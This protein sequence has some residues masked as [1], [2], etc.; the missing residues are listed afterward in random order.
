MT[1]LHHQHLHL[2]GFSPIESLPWIQTLVWRQG[3]KAILFPR[4]FPGHRRATPRFASMLG[5][6]SEIFPAHTKCPTRSST[7]APAPRTWWAPARQQYHDS[8]RAAAPEQHS[9]TASAQVLE[10]QYVQC[11]APQSNCTGAPRRRAATTTTWS[12]AR[13]IAHKLLLLR[14]C[15]NRPKSRLKSYWNCF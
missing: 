1:C 6:V 5:Y 3:G 4:L 15:K 12:L 11:A 9:S 10:H 14:L 8:T 13:F 7:A 2:V